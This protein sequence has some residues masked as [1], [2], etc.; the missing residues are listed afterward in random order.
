MIEETNFTQIEKKVYFEQKQEVLFKLEIDKDNQ[1][2]RL[3][4]QEINTIYENEFDL[5]YNTL[6]VINSNDINFQVENMFDILNPRLVLNRFFK[7]EMKKV[8][9]R[10]ELESKLENYS[11]EF[12]E[13]RVMLKSLNNLESVIQ[14]KN[15]VL[16]KLISSQDEKISSIQKEFSN[17]TD[18]ITKQI[19]HITNLNFTDLHQNL[20]DNKLA[21]EITKPKSSLD[22]R[23]ESIKGQ[24]RFCVGK[25]GGCSQVN[26]LSSLW[27]DNPYT[28]DDGNLYCKA[29]YHS[30]ILDE[31]GGFFVVKQVGRIE[32]FPAATR[33]GITSNSYSAYNAY[34]IHSYWDA[35]SDIYTSCCFVKNES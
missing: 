3:F 33:N 30:E 9:T 4:N 26:G 17:K 16:E 6:S 32:N 21:N 22:I 1:K 23:F 10:L 2:I 8:E 34:T 27:G 31:N 28:C 29:S 35:P 7:V 13:T 14:K 19:I 15:I 5:D 24:V 11:K 12:K 25:N 18:I 20:K